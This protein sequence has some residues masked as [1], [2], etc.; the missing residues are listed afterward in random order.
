VTISSPANGA[1]YASGASITFSR[2]VSDTQDGNLTSTLVWRSSIDG[3]IGVGG[4][5]TRTLTSGT[6]SITA[7]STDSGGMVT[8]RVVSITVAAAPPTNTAPSV[9]ISSP[10]NGTNYAAGASVTFTG[11]ASDTQDGNLTSSIVWRSNVD[12]QLGTGGS[13]TR[14]LTSGTHTITATVSDSGALTAQQSVNVNVA[15]S[16]PPQPSTSPTLTASGYKVNDSPRVALT[17]QNLTVAR[18]D[19]YR[20]GG[21]VATV[22]NNGSVT[23]GTL[24]KGAGTYTYKV[25]AAGTTTCTNQASVTF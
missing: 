12:G 24:P 23:D 5:F 8:Q 2:S 7:T 19:I 9:T 17:W 18:V 6:H 25:C 21:K 16:A 3:Q 14:T 4:S 11:S 22:A 20:N 10:A 13:L 15:A 1:S